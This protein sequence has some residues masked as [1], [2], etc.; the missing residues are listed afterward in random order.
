MSVEGYKLWGR[1][2]HLCPYYM[3]K[4]RLQSADLI[5]VPYQYVVDENLGKQAGLDLT[6]AVLI[7]DE[8]HN[9]SRVCEE[10]G[11]FEVSTGLL[12]TCE[13][14]QPEMFEDQSIDFTGSN[15]DYKTWTL[16]Q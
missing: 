1:Q 9:L 8:G 3:M 14:L 4:N 10:M 6:D 13:Q 15:L 7:F 5:I 11:D 16:E 2:Q 12:A